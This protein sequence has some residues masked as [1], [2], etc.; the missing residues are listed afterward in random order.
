MTK[1]ETPTGRAQAHLRA[2]FTLV[3][4]LV[5][6][7]IIITLAALIFAVTGKIRDSARQTTAMTALRQIG[8]ANVAYSTENNG[9]INV[10]RDAG[11]WGPWEGNGMRYAT[12]SFIGRMAPYLFADLDTGNQKA[13]ATE[14]KSSLNALFKTT[15]P[16]TMEGTLFEGV[17]VTSDGSGFSNPISVSDSLRPKWGKDNPPLTVSRFGDPSDILYLTYGRYYFDKKQA[18]AYRPLP[19][20]GDRTRTIYYLPNRKGIFAFLDGHVEMLTPPISER[21]FPDRPID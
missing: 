9:A 16:K 20:P 12:N 2:G 8:I 14:V 4:L 3:E 19:G 15:D 10:V 13:F 1:T 6:I 11:E 18:S 7:T 5:S 17:P 21:Y